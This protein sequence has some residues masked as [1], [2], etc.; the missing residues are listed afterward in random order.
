MELIPDVYCSPMSLIIPPGYCQAVYSMSLTG[1][2]Q[3]ILVT[4]GHDLDEYSGGNTGLPNELFSRFQT[5]LKSI[6]SSLYTIT[7]CRVYVGQDGPD[8][9][10][11][12]SDAAPVVGT[13]SASPCRRTAPPS[14]RSARRWQGVA[15]EAGCSCRPR[16]VQ[17]RRRGGHHHGQPCGHPGAVHRMAG[18]ARG[19][20]RA[21]CPAPGHPPLHRQECHPCPDRDQLVHDRPRDLHPASAPP[22][23]SEPAGGRCSRVAEG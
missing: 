12:E 7:G 23:L 2:S 11:Y 17:R 21:R 3:P 18:V 4:C 20:H 13:G 10:V 15:T 6:V 8:S 22:P 1:D 16:R 14:W 5:T 19:D 9:L